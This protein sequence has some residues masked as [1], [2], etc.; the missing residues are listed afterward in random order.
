VNWTGRDIQSGAC[1]GGGFRP[2][3]ARRLPLKE[4]LVAPASAKLD[5][6]VTYLGRPAGGLPVRIC[7]RIEPRIVSFADYTD[8]RFGGSPVKRACAR[9]L[10]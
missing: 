1:S 5:V 6:A 9:A 8:Y 10:N 3:H 7:H 2:A 4:P